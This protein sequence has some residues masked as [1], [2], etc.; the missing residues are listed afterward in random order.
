MQ[1][2]NEQCGEGVLPFCEGGI[3]ARR[4]RGD[5]A[6]ASSCGG[7]GDRAL[8]APLLYDGG[9]GL[10]TLGHS[11]LTDRSINLSLKWEVSFSSSSILC[12]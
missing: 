9:Q 6:S 12:F 5:L 4:L 1:L 2:G 3:A 8:P 10:L 7:L 11:C